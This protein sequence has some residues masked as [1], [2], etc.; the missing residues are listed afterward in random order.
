MRVGIDRIPYARRDA[1][2]DCAVGM[3]GAM[4]MYDFEGRSTDGRI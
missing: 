2:V 3:L 4:E 1:K